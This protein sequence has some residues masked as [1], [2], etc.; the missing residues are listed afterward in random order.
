MSCLSASPYVSKMTLLFRRDQS[1]VAGHL[2]FSNRSS[3]DE[4]ALT[5]ASLDH[6]VHGV[7]FPLSPESDSL[8]G[9]YEAYDRRR[10]GPGSERLQ[11]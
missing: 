8:Q 6:P 1:I 9:F 11:T 10:W 5:I 7:H 2:V 4:S 3:A